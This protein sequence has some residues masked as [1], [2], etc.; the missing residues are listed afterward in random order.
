MNYYELVSMTLTCRSISRKQQQGQ[1]L[2]KSTTISKF[3]IK[4]LN[5]NSLLL[6][7][8]LY[9]L[10][11]SYFVNLGWTY[12]DD[13]T[14]KE[15]RGHLLSDWKSNDTTKKLLKFLQISI[16]RGKLEQISNPKY[17]EMEKI[18]LNNI[19]IEKIPYHST[20]APAKRRT[21]EKNWSDDDLTMKKED[22]GGVATLTTN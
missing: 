5:N 18:S 11:F 2:E 15:Q 4:K 14:E 20:Y 7:V 13:M 8:L 6:I 19:Y 3:K 1:L 9:K 10:I 12:D 22:F 16:P 17:L 21:A